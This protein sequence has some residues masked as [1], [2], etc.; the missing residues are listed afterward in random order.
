MMKLFVSV[1]LLVF[2]FSGPV[3]AQSIRRML[4]NADYTFYSENFETAI[5]LYQAVLDRRPEND[6]AKYH[7]MIAQYLT[8]KRTEDLAPLIEFYKSANTGDRFF[9]YWMGRIY[10]GKYEFDLAKRHFRKF[11]SADAFKSKEIIAET[12]QFIKKIELAEKY[13]TNPSGFDLEQLEHPINSEHADLSPVVYKEHNA[14]VFA[15]SRPI[16][17][18]KKSENEFLVFHSL[19]DDGNWS[20]P[21][22][23]VNLGTL[24]ATTTA[25]EVVNEDGKMYIYKEKGRGDL[26]YST[27]ANGKWSTPRE[28]K[29][30]VRANVLESDFFINDKED[31]ILFSVMKGYQIDLYESRKNKTGLWTK[32]RPL[33]GVN[34]KWDED[35]PFLTNDGET[36]YFSSNRPASIGGFDVFKSSWDNRRKRW[37]TPENLGFPIN[38]IDDEVNFHLNK[39]NISGFLSSNRLHSMGDF[40]IYFFGES[41]KTIVQGTVTDFNDRPMAN[42]TVTFQSIV[43]K[44]KSFLA[45][46]DDEGYYKLEVTENHKF[47]VEAAMADEV[48]SKSS[49]TTRPPRWMKVMENNLIVGSGGQEPSPRE[50]KIEKLTEVIEEH[51]AE[52][53]L[54]TA[55]ISN[56]YFDQH[57]AEV[58]HDAELVI[59]TMVRLLNHHPNMKIVIHGHADEGED[60]S[61]GLSLSRA[62]SVK[63]VLVDREIDA[64]RIEVTGYGDSK[65]LASADDEMDGRELNRRT[66]VSI[67][68]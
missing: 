62:E 11:L 13:Y 46:T 3:G 20:D 21:I 35:S 14:M 58:P 1:I 63:K 5:E 52:N 67:V 53:R 26:Y 32:P 30:E 36:L 6:K 24:P 48:L 10:Y 42:V 68:E 45:T 66:E 43:D 47:I 50:E 18:V 65:L 64:E 19:K 54:F 51:H 49:C 16:S 31:H 60:D 17:G 38:T 2:T 23:L 33:R 12:R 28:A 55:N 39:D 4:I 34:S 57:S 9:N 22:A 15:S 41:G 40:D 44:N 27:P 37:T 8:V 25:V 29:S 59:R 7:Q 56:I 61:Q